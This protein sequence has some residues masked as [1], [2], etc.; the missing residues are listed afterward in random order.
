MNVSVYI[1]TSLDGFIAR[2]DGSVDWLEHESGDED[3]GY[4]AFIETVDTLVMGRNTFEKVR[5]FDGDWP[6][7]LPVVV[8]SRTLSDADVPADLVGRVTMSPQD[9]AELV[10]ELAG[11]GS[12][13]VYIDGGRLI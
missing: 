3:Y 13:H 5:S 7:Q 9:P 11:R 6:Y 4:R 10:E 8:L 12:E 1:A 2:A